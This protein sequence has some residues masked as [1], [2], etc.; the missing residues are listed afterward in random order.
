MLRS[1][2][3]TL[4]KKEKKN[5]NRNCKKETEWKV[6][7]ERNDIIRMKRDWKKEDRKEKDREEREAVVGDEKER[8]E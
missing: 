4:R 7:R 3:A 1:R 8:K 2:N 5:G 6:K